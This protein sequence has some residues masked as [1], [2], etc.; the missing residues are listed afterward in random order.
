MSGLE[1]GLFPRGNVQVTSG[2]AKQARSESFITSNPKNPNNLIAASKKFSN[3]STYHFSIGVRVSF[4]AGKTWQD[5]TLPTL[6]EWGSFVGVGGK[7]AAAGMTDPAVAFDDFGNAFMAGEPIS[8]GAN[9][10]INTV[11]MYV[12]R[13]TDGGLSWNA[14]F[15]LH[16]GD[17]SD[18]KSWIG[19]DN[20]PSSPHYGN[21]Y[22]VWGAGSPLRFARSTDH[23]A[24]WK[25]VSTGPPGSQLTATTFAP[26]VTVGLDGTVHISWH[27]D[28][29]DN[30]GP[31][32]TTIEYMRSTDG[33]DSFEVQRSIVTGVQSLRGNLQE[34]DGW[35]VFPGATFRVITVVTACAFRVGSFIG[36]HSRPNAHHYIVAWSD[37]RE[38][39]ARVY[40]RAS[41]DGGATF[42]GPGAG[43]PLLPPQSVTNTLHHFHPQIIA[44]GAGVIGCAY[45]EYGPK[46]G[47]NRIDVILSASFD[48]GATFTETVIVTDR[49]WD[50]AIDAPFSHGD[51]K[52][53]FIGEYFG[54][55]S[56]K[57]SFDVLWTDT[58]TG[59][60]ELFFDRVATSR[61]VRIDHGATVE[62]VL[63][64]VVQDGGGAVFVNGHI[65]V[66]PPRGPE[67]DMLQALAALS[68]AGN[69]SG[70][71]G[72]SLIKSTLSV[73]A[74]I[75]K[76]ASKEV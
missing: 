58:R 47:S 32:G 8:Y 14:P 25:G 46:N 40:Y 28:S 43:T 13:S 65:I 30:G 12:Y 2:D 24:T 11:G 16:V 27:F 69:I 62:Q 38:G 74:T 64:G 53:T 57:S 9:G 19:C 50:P 55:D 17:S 36:K 42:A 71:A 63:F 70:K 73:I 52:V 3:P 4:D 23:G 59:V 60:Q 5:A 31:A 22:I 44:T 61:F 66:I 39:V 56:D 41:A 45:Y 7:D 6:A 21:I 54:L 37:Y 76:E 49:P 48:E 26:E 18:D 68:A 67:F 1:S 72:R 15:P 20:D 29:E 51:P 33:G 75:A 10:Q 35:P 34:I